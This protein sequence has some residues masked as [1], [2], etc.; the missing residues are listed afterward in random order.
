MIDTTL[1]DNSDLEQLGA[2][3]LLQEIDDLRGVLGSLALL[4]QERVALPL[5]YELFAGEIEL[6]R[7]RLTYAEQLQ[8]GER[9]RARPLPDLSLIPDYPG[10]S[11]KLVSQWV[12]NVRHGQPC[13][14]YVGRTV[15]GHRDLGFGN[16]FK[17]GRDGAEGECVRLFEA[18]LLERPELLARV[19]R[20]LKGKLLGCW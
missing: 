12:V 10:R 1:V 7:E 11:L 15:A 13:D 6:V 19:R 17:V 20:E 5:D 4:A 18:Y 14:V 3:E 9:Q 8:R 16:P 2:A